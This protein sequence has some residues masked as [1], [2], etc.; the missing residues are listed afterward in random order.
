MRA[1]ICEQAYRAVRSKYT[2]RRSGYP[3][4]SFIFKFQSINSIALCKF[5]TLHGLLWMSLPLWIDFDLQKLV[6]T[7]YKMMTGIR[8][9]GANRDE[10]ELGHLKAFVCFHAKLLG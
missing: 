2:L 8:I 3:I 1:Y 4:P 10:L 9:D 6:W 5:S 7:T